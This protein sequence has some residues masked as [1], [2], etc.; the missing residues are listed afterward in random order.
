VTRPLARPAATFTVEAKSQLA[1]RPGVLVLRRRE[2]A[3]LARRRRERW[4]VGD[5]AV[6][7]DFTAI[8]LGIERFAIRGAADD[9]LLLGGMPWDL[10]EVGQV[11]TQLR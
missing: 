8:V 10:I 9:A 1:S 3:R 2:A 5:T 4:S 6:C 11:W 7:G